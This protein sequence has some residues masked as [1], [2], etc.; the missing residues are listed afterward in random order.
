MRTTFHY[1]VC[2][3]KHLWA[4]HLFLLCLLTGVFDHFEYPA[5]ELLGHDLQDV[6]EKTGPLA[7]EF[8]PKHC[9]IKQ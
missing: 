1:E 6:L 9:Q 2:V 8:V 7:F 5:M 4:I 3:L